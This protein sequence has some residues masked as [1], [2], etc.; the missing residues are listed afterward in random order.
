MDKKSQKVTKDPRRVKQGKKSYEP[1]MKRLKEQI[2]EDNQLSTL[3]TS[4]PTCDPTPSTCNPTPSTSSPTCDPMP[5]TS[6]H[7]TRPNDTYVNGFA[8][9]AVLAIGVSVFFTYNTFQHK[10]LISDCLAAQYEQKQP[11]KRRHAL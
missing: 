5:S 4:S 11:P 8:L 7:T 9:L 2:L 1:C 3:S 6:S 10:K